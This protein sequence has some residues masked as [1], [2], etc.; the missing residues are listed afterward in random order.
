MAGEIPGNVWRRLRTW[1]LGSSLGAVSLCLPVVAHAAVH[2]HDRRPLHH[3]SHS[4]HVA[5][6][7]TAYRHY[8][9]SDH[10]ISS[11]RAPR[12]IQADYR[13]DHHYDSLHDRRRDAHLIRADYRTG[14][15]HYR[16]GRHV[17]A[18]FYHSRLQCVPYA[19][20]VSHIELSGNAFL[21]WAEAAGRYQRGNVPA[22]GAVLNFRSTGRMPLGHVAV[23]TAIMNPRMILVTQANW[24]PGTITNDV[25]VEDVSPDNDWTAVRV[26]YGNSTGMGAAY[27]TYGFI[28]N[29][30]ASAQTIYAANEAGR[31]E[32]AEAPELAPIAAAA[33][34][35]NLR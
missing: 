20:E 16:Y 34:D 11:D 24:V 5:F 12:L 1:F 33:P 30:P 6:S 22:V 27:P 21:W 18:R 28:Y 17:V 31:N 26:E 8:E 13:R 35:R 3:V 9:R 10:H 4:S 7:H 15:A 23:V 14:H 29:R 2:H 25:T 32:V 19:R